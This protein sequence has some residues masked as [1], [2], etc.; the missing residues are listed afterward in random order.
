MSTADIADRFGTPAYVYE[1]ARVRAAEADLRAMVPEEAS[2][3]YSLKANPHPLVVGEL[4]RRGCLA[5]VSSLGETDTALRA[6]M[7]A[8]RVLLTGPAKTSECLDHALSRGVRRMSVDSPTDL[9]RVGAAA[10]R[11]GMDVECLLR[12]NADQPVPG[13]GLAM[14]GTA[15]QFGADGTWVA[16]QPELFLGAGRARVTGLHLYMG[17]NITDEQTLLR[18][19]ETAATLA[20]RLRA[21]LGDLTEVDLGGGFGTPYA[22]IGDRP[23]WIGLRAGL[24]EL[25]DRNLPG[26][27]HGRP[28]VSFESGR[29][30]T[31]DCGTLLCRVMDVKPS[32]ED[33]FTVLDGGINHLG[34]MVG[35]RRIPPISPTVQRVEPPSPDEPWVRTTV[36]GPLCT[37]L[38]TFVRR[39]ALP[40]HLPGDVLAV[41]NVGAY[42][43]TASLLAFLGH[44]AP[45]EV[46]TDGGDVLDVSRLHLTRSPAT[47]ILE[48]VR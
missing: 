10:G 26:W 34:G 4:A 8:R 21:R 5:E 14:T 32:K 39:V 15:S 16:E 1:L 46:V 43:L 19:F 38:D 22:R 24:T 23:R 41:P 30:L 29:Y 44:P 18:Q 36:V 28:H 20:A 33:V 13:M 25:L 6:G 11:A 2:V 17:T 40:P 45:V 12:V 48:E 27:R 42:G 7:P 35:L 37:P 47:Q 3:Y 31:G 9:A